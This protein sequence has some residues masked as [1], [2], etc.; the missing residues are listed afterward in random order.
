M[1]SAQAATSRAPA[2]G[3]AEVD[4]DRRIRPQDDFYGFAVGG[5]IARVHGPAYMPGWSAGRELQLRIYEALDRDVRALAKRGG[6]D[7]NARK[8]ADIYASYM[9]V[10]RIDAMG[11]RPLDAWFRQFDAATKPDDIVRAIAALSAHG[12]DIGVG[13]WVHADDEAPTRYLADFVQSDLG[14]PERDYY[15]GEE[16]RLRQVRDA[17]RAHAERVLALAGDKDAGE[18][19]HAIVALETRLARAQWTQVATRVPGATSHRHTRAQ[20]AT[21][22]PGFDLA[23]FASRI[24]VP[25]ATDRFNVGQP[26]Y[27]AAYAKALT[28][29][30]MPVWR[31]YL[32]LRL[33]DHLARFLPRPYRDEADRFF[34]RTLYG[35]TASRPR[36]L[37]AMGVLEEAMGDALGRLYVE[38][39]FP[40]E[41]RAQARR[42]LDNVIAAFRRRI[43]ASDWLDETSRR[44]ALAKLD[45]LVIRMGA[46]ETI[47]DYSRLVTRPADAVGNWLRARALRAQSEIDKLNLP[48]DREEWTMS[49]Q[50]VNGYYSVSRNQVVLPAALLQPPYFQAGADAAV[51]YGALG[52]FIA[53]ELS[54]AFDR[55]GS[56]YDGFGKRVEWMTPDDRAEFERRAQAF[57]TQYGRYEAAP[58]HR[59]NGELTVGENI[60]DNVGLAVA[61]DA[62]RIALNG[63]ASPVIDGLTG[64]QRFFLGFARIWAS[65]PIVTP[66]G[67]TQAL[68]DTHA[69]DRWRVIGAVT[70]H[71]A[72]YRA[73]G[74]GDADRMFLP[75]V[76]RTR[77]W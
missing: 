23:L 49:A 4:L 6:D 74:V 8:L 46:P 38:R 54:H 50:S 69:P 75:P 43:D 12:L 25:D 7:A 20:L 19:A 3:I 31:A 55:A 53:H 52:F 59:L 15:V 44:G 29:T 14:L 70:N 30:P 67:V 17:Y 66:A 35:A 28:E 34:T 9:D 33:I 57:V 71:D 18:L 47:R 63:D 36:W 58:G 51:N 56:Q 21:T 27:F 10:A 45:N 60:A 65:E 72:F 77:I 5:W 24:G 42:V 76:Q 1:E 61:Y 22:Y 16:P 37:R 62:W 73:F 48:V 2:S 26:D 39:H 41:A 13:T 32:K 64:D 40:A 11:L 68:A